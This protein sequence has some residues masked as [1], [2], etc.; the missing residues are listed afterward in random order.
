MKAVILNADKQ[1]LPRYNKDTEQDEDTLMVVVQVAFQNDDGSTHHT[2]TY[3][4]L[5]EESGDD[6]KSYFQ[7]QADA[8]QADIDNSEATAQTVED[9]ALADEVISKLTS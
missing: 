2:Q 7:D 8:M 5:P 1:I 4:R 3:A 6:P 9:S